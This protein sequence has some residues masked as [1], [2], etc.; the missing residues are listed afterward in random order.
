VTERVFSGMNAR[1]LPVIR[2]VRSVRRRLGRA[3]G[4]A[5]TDFRLPLAPIN[6]A[7]TALFAGESQRILRALDGRSGYPAGASWVVVLRREAGEIAPRSKPAGL[8]P[9]LHDPT[10][11]A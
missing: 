8:S 10:G 11:S 1:L 2:T 3:A 9:D 7:L 5:N 4:K 6:Q